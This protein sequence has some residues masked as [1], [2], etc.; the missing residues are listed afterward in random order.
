MAYFTMSKL[1]L[2]WALKKPP[3][4]KYPFAA[5]RVL[6]KSRGQLVFLKDKCVYCN[7]CA[8]KCPTKALTVNRAAKKWGIERLQCISCG[9]C[10]EVCPKDCLELNTD[11]GK[12]SVTK[13]KEAY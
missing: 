2:K 7:V 11:H 5:R 13:D 6:A 3:T 12:P 9:Y 10:V 1:A 8:K 4:R